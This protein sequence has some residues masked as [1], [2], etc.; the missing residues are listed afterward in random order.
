VAGFQD[1]AHAF[2]LKSALLAAKPRCS[3]HSSAAKAERPTTDA[4]TPSWTR[5]SR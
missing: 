3:P 1:L 5:A 4:T 2:D